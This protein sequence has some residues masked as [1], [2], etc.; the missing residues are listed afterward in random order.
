MKHPD[1]F[2]QLHH[3]CIVVRNL[4]TAV[5]YYESIGVGPWHDFPPLDAFKSDLKVPDPAA[6][7][8]LRYR[9][10]DLGNVQLQLC[11]P[12][13][14]N[15]A[16]MHFLKTRGEGVFHLGFTVPDCNKG[17]AQGNE[18]GLQTLMRGRRPDLSGFTYFDTAE[19]GAGV[20]LEI[21]ATKP[22]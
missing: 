15:S 19:K 8:K 3:I 7:F 6:F 9:Y 14:G 10:A 13:A 16:Q 5:A 2:Q 22:S 20:T 21:R 1:L 18:M 11:E 4:E 17:E 12:G